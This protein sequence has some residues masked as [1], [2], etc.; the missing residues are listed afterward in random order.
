MYNKKYWEAEENI[1][2]VKSA[3]QKLNNFLEGKEKLED[4]F[5]LKKWAW[6]FAVTDLTYTYHGVAL[7]S[8][9]FYY[10]PINGKFEPIGSDGHK[11]VP[12]YS[13][14]IVK[15]RPTLDS[16]NFSKAKDKVSNKEKKSKK[17]FLSIEKD[18]F[19]Q[20]GQINYNFYTEYVKAI[21]KITSKKF[22][23]NF[24]QIRREKIKKI[25]SG[26]YTDSYIYDYNT[27]RRSGI[28]I[29][30]FS[31]KEIY[32]RAQSLSKQFSVN[33]K[34]LFIEENQNKLIFNN[35]DYN[36]FFLSGGKILCNNYDI[37]ISELKINKKTFYLKKNDK[38]NNSCKKISFKDNISNKIINFD[39]NKYNSFDNKPIKTKYNFLEYFYLS[40][41]KLKLKNN[42]TKID[43]N[44]FIPKGYQV[45]ING[46]QEIIL[47]NNAFIFSNSNWIVGDLDQK[48]FIHGTKINHGGGII[49]Y[50]NE[51][52]S[53]F[54]NCKFEFL[55]GLKPRRLLDDNNFFEDRLIYG[56]INIFQTNVVIKNS[57]FKN[58]YSEDALNIISSKYLIKNTLFEKT[59]YDAIDIDFSNGKILKSY[60]NNIGNDAIDFSGSNSEISFLKFKNIGDKSISVGENSLLNIYNIKGENS[61]I[62][63]ASKD[64][65]KTY[66][67]NVEF[68]NVDYPFAAYQKKKAYKYGKLI[69]NNFSV[70]N[71]K[72]KYVRD[73]NSI[74]F[75]DKSKKKLGKSNKEINKIIE[76]I[77]WSYGN[78]F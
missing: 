7:K 23:D 3:I 61:L 48:T 59:K 2:I 19:F 9:K 25:N 50:D 57:I 65:S 66:A 70:N 30:Y 5:D 28:G 62:G 26:I 64:G 46:G 53:F 55:T 12:N 21:Q 51:K 27:M 31:K 38:F 45:L 10:N 17:F 18:F 76:N 36:N 39:I 41:K 13:K 40:G 56:S 1:K 68:I 44:V 35:Y 77:I 71:F 60:F 78:Y 74:I 63:I 4:V 67:E 54:T 16:T 37:H 34:A 32:R 11:L 72:Y 15:K 29:Y 14:Y 47:E 73:F 75:D 52:K 49:I 22:L 24:F 69:L 43:Q 42:S 33:S 58:I 20:N 6:F 8:V